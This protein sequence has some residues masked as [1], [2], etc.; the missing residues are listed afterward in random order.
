MSIWT[1][2]LWEVLSDGTWE[3][4]FGAELVAGGCHTESSP[5]VCRGKV[6]MLAW[7]VS[8]AHCG[9]DTSG[10]MLPSPAFSLGQTGLHKSTFSWPDSWLMWW[11][12]GADL[13]PSK[14][15]YCNIS[16]EVCNAWWFCIWSSS[17]YTWL[18][19]VSSSKH[20]KLM[21]WHLC[22]RP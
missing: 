13:F 16:R 12:D 3:M 10:N 9:S 4:G 8:A 11:T 2:R 20:A 19:A 7:C 14:W 17:P 21:D 5:W 22:H 18:A 1:I 6:A 15:A